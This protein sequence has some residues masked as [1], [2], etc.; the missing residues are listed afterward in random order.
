M[1]VT[2]AHTDEPKCGDMRTLV[3]IALPW[4][5]S[6]LNFASLDS[7]TGAGVGELGGLSLA[8]VSFI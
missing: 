8:A 6:L 5:L 2:R 1:H 7:T 4:F 3:T